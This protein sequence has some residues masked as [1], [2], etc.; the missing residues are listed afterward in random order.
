MSC[1]LCQSLHE[2]FG[3]IPCL[4][5]KNNS[6]NNFFTVDVFGKEEESTDVA[7]IEL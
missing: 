7:A 2:K 5:L 4:E 1:L 6:H 3:C